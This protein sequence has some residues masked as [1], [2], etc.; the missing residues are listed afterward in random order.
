MT[1]EAKPRKQ[2]RPQLRVVF[3]TNVLYTGSASDLIR[4][5]AVN[6]IKESAMQTVKSGSSI[7]EALCRKKP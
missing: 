7:L 2:Q 6:L 5:E 1:I 4:Q 3:D